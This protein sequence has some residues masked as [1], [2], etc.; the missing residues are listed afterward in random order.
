[1]RLSI[2]LA[3]AL[4][5]ALLAAAPA[6]AGHVCVVGGQ[7]TFA[8]NDM[9]ATCGAP[10]G[11]SEVNSLSVG[12]NAAGDIV[13]TDTNPISDA[14][15][16]GGCT[17]SGNSATCPRGAGYAFSLGDGADT[18]V[19][20]TVPAAGVSSGGA[21]ADT[22]T[23][24]PAADNLAGGDGNDTIAGGAGDD[25]VV[26]DSGDDVV[27]GGDGNDA[28]D[29]GESGFG[30]VGSGGND[31]LNGDAGDDLLCGESGALP[32]ADA[33]NGGDGL[34]HAFYPGSAGVT[35][36]LDGAPNDG[37]P[38]EGDN[39]RPDVESLT[40]GSGSDTLVGND[41]PNLLDG[42]G[43]ADALSGLGGNDVLTDSGG[44]VAADREDG[45]AGDDTLAAG[46]GPDT[47]AGGDGE[48]AVVDY[49]GRSAPVSVTLDG[50]AD[51]GQ[52]GEGDNAGPDVED[53]TGGSAAD[54]LTG[55]ASDNELAGGGGDDTIA[56]GGGNDGLF[57]QAGRDTVD[58]G[59]GRDRIDGGAGADTLKSRDGVTDRVE[60]AGG[61]DS[62][63]G[64]ARDDI[65]GDCENVDIAPPTA[66]SI[67]RV[68]VT[69][70][71]FVVVR[72][73]C[74]GVERSCAGAVIVKTVRRIA[75]R[76]IKLGQ[77]NYRLR[78][79]TS[80]ILRARIAAKDRKA[81]KR[82]RRVKIRTVVTNVNSDTGSQTNAT[83]L[84][85]VTTRGL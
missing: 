77:V 36:S 50:N 53:V 37:V 16:P 84:S 15:G 52:A 23:G 34:D 41:G 21:G 76:F 83:R 59:A 40:G 45:G 60:C 82:A 35:V 29:G 24:G 67:V 85:T 78:G 65:S 27:S 44:D 51:D 55:N 1:M 5:T 18:A 58:G 69:R 4:T 22:L 2:S 71:G 72:V 68:V 73:A 31:V 28:L 14:D 39:V 6:S 63:Q 10:A 12:T 81:L 47:Y 61:T 46:A 49:V 32:D 64:E 79:G 43:G 56:G 26:G 80:K 30:C 7:A 54:T 20:G 19:V 42:A 25:F 8:A 48:D 74:P 66:V 57:G 70:A 75:K 3:L 9:A 13:F 33:L 62:V 11:P 38:G 17:A